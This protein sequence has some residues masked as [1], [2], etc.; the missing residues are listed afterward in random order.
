MFC[1][2]FTEIPAAI[3]Q[4]VFFS[5][6][7]PNYLNYGAIGW[8]IGHEFTHGFDDQG[9]QFNGVGDLINWW[10][11]KTQEEYSDRAQCIIQQYSN[12]TVKEVGLNVSI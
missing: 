6:A 8:I 5:S 7:R 4:D 11:P 2:F 10:D 1:F 3:L 9:S 12:Y